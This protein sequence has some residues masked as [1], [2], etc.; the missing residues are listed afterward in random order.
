M[1]YSIKV[2][3]INGKEGSNIKGFASVVFFDSFKITNILCIND[4][5]IK[6]KKHIKLRDCFFS[7]H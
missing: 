3:I 6:E 5:S 7:N 2:N 1:K 4:S